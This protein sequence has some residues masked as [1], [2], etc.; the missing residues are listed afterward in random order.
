M[1]EERGRGGT[2]W[3]GH[4]EGILTQRKSQKDARWQ[5]LLS[6]GPCGLQPPWPWLGSWTNWRLSTFWCWVEQ[7]GADGAAWTKMCNLVWLILALELPGQ[8]WVAAI[9][10]WK[11][12]VLWVPFCHSCFI[13]SLVEC[14]VW[15]SYYLIPV[16]VGVCFTLPNR[17]SPCCLSSWERLTAATQATFTLTHPHHILAIIISCLCMETSPPQWSKTWPS[18]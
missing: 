18:Q 2:F 15:W 11:G 7:A 1:R 10:S 4:I 9:P 3:W 5:T 16:F 6:P 12:Q 14:K 13:L 8:Q 17:L